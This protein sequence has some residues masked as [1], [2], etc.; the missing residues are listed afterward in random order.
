MIYV[1]G[2][3]Y[4]PQEWVKCN[5]LHEFLESYQIEFRDPK[6]GETVERVV[7]RELVRQVYDIEGQQYG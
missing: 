3:K 5:L 4:N 2:E 7:K 1:Y 6:T